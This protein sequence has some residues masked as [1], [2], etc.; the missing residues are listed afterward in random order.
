MK[1]W[2]TSLLLVSIAAGAEPPLR[3][4]PDNPHYF[5]FRGKPAV[6]ITSGEH[7]GAMLNGRFDYR[8]YLET[9][10]ADR[11]N[12]TRIFS[13]MYREVPGSFNISRNTL[14]PEEADFVQPFK[15]L[16]SQK[17]D[18]ASWNEDYFRRLRD[19]MSEA[20]K[21]GVVGSGVWHK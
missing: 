19:F 17:Y 9:L 8:K 4:H 13:G 12:L 3:L 18:L 1:C 10:A 7:Y 6:L 14:A 16:G 21:R 11:L 5:L 20:S 2:W 15:R